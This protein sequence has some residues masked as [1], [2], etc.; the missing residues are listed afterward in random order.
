MDLY[1]FQ[2]PN[3]IITTYPTLPK[4]LHESVSCQRLV[5]LDYV[6][7]GK[8]AFCKTTKFTT[9]ASLSFPYL[10]SN[11]ITYILIKLPI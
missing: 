2:K 6:I 1:K 7:R 8:I 5:S 9:F 11:I 10:K 3:N 4:I